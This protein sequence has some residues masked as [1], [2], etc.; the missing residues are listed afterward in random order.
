MHRRTFMKAVVPAAAGVG[1]L[2]RGS[3]EAAASQTTRVSRRRILL[4]SSWQTV[5]IGD[6]AHTPGVLALLERYVP[7]AEVTLWAS[8]LDVAVR[9]LLRRRFPHLTVLEHPEHEAVAGT[10][11]EAALRDTDLLVHGSGPALVGRLAIEAAQ[12]MGKP[13]GIYGVTLDSLDAKLQET[14]AGAQ[15]FF[16]RDTAS[17]SYLRGLQLRCP[18]QEFAPDGTFALD[19]RDDRAAESWLAAHD[20]EPGRFLC[21]VPRLRWTP[22]AS[23][24]ELARQGDAVWA[25]RLRENDRLGEIDHAKLREA[26][27]AFVRST[28]QRVLLCPEMTYQVP[29]L[30]PLL[31]DALPDDVKPAVVSRDAYWYTDE[32]ASTYARAA[33]VVSCE[34]H[35][36]IIALATGTPAIHVRQPTDTRKGQMWRDI[37]LDHWLLE[38]DNTTGAQIAER[39]LE[40]VRDPAGTAARVAGAL[41]VARGRQEASMRVVANAA[42]VSTANAAVRAP[43]LDA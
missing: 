9:G 18:V 10:A 23:R 27:V 24:V 29:L 13:Y 20:L 31:F 22:Y 26:I 21:V 43:R 17:L 25:E 41:R 42:G 11:V 5:N 38:V 28:G 15:F 8:P 3:A 34:M 7:E 19:I 16:C 2:A 37:G 30:R 40:I 4:R 33:A 39:V 1:A 6:I 35:S 32:A 12:A 36:P 14:V